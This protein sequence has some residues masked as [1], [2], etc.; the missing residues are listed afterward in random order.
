MEHE[1]SILGGQNRAAIGRYLSIA[2]SM[3][4]SVIGASVVFFVEVMRTY[5]LA[6]NIPS[7]VLWP[8]TAGIIY[9]GLYWF[10]ERIAW[11]FEIIGRLLNVPN[12]EGKWKCEG[13]STDPQT[14]SSRPWTGEVT[15]VQSWDKLRVRLKTAQSGSNSITAALVY[16]RAEGYRLLY[17]YKNDPRVGEQELRSHHGAAEFLFSPDLNSAEGEYFTGFGR[18][19]YGTMKLTRVAK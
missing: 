10:F 17:N 18:G 8:L 19:N 15:I 9:T 1:Y 14:S 2:A 6:K 3:I 7:F 4:S 12:L 5:E 11:R 13:Q 16:D